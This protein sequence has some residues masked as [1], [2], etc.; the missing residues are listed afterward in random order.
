MDTRVGGSALD[1]A[2]TRDVRDP[3]GGAEPGAEQLGLERVDG[4]ARLEAVDLDVM[5]LDSCTYSDRLLGVEDIMS[6]QALTTWTESEILA[7]VRDGHGMPKG[8]TGRAHELASLGLIDTTGTWKLTPRGTEKL[9]AK[10]AAKASESNSYQARWLKECR[11]HGA[12]QRELD[13]VLA[14]LNAMG[15]PWPGQ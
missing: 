14:K 12:T 7:A 15:L 8:A 11:D 10:P 2:A 4:W 3:G 6:K 1:I 13:A 5:S 9:T